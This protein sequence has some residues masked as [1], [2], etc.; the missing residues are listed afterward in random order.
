M[1][2]GAAA[3]DEADET[4]RLTLS[5]MKIGALRARIRA[6]AITGV[7]TA[8]LVEKRYVLTCSA[9]RRATGLSP[10]PRPPQQ[11]HGSDFVRL[12]LEHTRRRAAVGGWREKLLGRPQL[13][14]RSVN[15]VHENFPKC[16]L[17]LSLEDSART[18]ITEEELLA[19]TFHVRVRSDGPVRRGGGVSEM[20]Q[21]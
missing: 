10:C 8:D 18:Q 21:C 3:V 1:V 12:I 20:A 15:G 14:R 13:L 17:R 2:G 7:R 11:P 6:L 16:A 5:N 4:A 19:T 9:S